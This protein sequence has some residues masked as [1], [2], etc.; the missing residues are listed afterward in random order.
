MYFSKFRFFVVS[1]DSECQVQQALFS[2]KPLEDSSYTFVTVSELPNVLGA[3][4]AV[5]IDRDATL[6]AER[7][8]IN[9]GRVVLLTSP[10][11]L[12][13][14]KDEE[15]FGVD[16]LWVLPEAQLY[17]ARLLRA[18]FARLAKTMKDSADMRRLQI[19]LHTAIDSI[20]DLVWYKDTAGAHLTV[21]DGFC[22]AVE[23]SKEQIYKRG[24]YYIWDIP[25]EEYEQGEYVCLESEDIVMEARKTCIFDE[26]VKLKTGMRLFKTYK[27]PLIDYD[28]QIFGT[29]GIA[30][31]VTDLGNINRELEVLLESMPFAIVVEDCNGVILSTN[32]MFSQFFGDTESIIGKNYTEWKRTALKEKVRVYHDEEYI[33][34]EEKGEERILKFNEKPIIDI[35]KDQIGSVGI[36]ADMTLQR[37]YE[38]Q[39]LQRANTDFLTQ[40][41]NRRSLFN[42]LGQE[43]ATPQ[44]AIFTVDLDCFKHVN[45]NFGHH[46]GDEAL[47]ITAKALRSCFP[48]DF[49]ARLGGDEFLVAIKGDYALEHLEQV[50]QRMIDTLNGLYAERSEFADLTAS[51]G[52]AL[53]QLAEGE[54]H[55]I[56][57]LMRHSDQALYHAKNS[58]KARYCVYP[59]LGN[60]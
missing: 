4:D 25:K 1:A 47:T 58:G 46:V 33:H 21:N 37:K 18:N 16:D 40:L 57:E 49:V 2:V 29:C 22:K 39:T 51:V 24:H 8:K 7:D 42:Y 10:E 13:K 19:C 59:F 11:A 32:K 23:K 14:L 17:D 28:G 6:L 45:D 38:E 55:N 60:A 31:D 54:T 3:N 41:N 27:S 36:F 56:E 44:L 43:E 30:H 50:A 9:A 5:I 20:P 52:I 26:K 12:A 48:N 15:L 34:I 35:F 53:S